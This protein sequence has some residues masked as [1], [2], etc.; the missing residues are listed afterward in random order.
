MKN[1]LFSIVI[2]IAVFII[3]AGFVQGQ[4]GKE[5]RSVSGFTGV[6]YGIPG[7]LYIKIGSPFSV[8]LEGDSR[9]LK[10][11]ETYIR[12][13]RLI[14][15]MESY[16]FFNDE[17]IDCYITMPSLK[18]LSVSGS[19]AARI[20]SPVNADALNLSVSG[21]GKIVAD[22]LTTDSFYSTISGSGDII[23]EGA[24][25][26]DRGNITISGSGSY[27]AG[28]FEIDKL[29]VNISGSGNC[30]CKPG[31]QLTAN[32]SGSGNVWYSG[33]PKLDVRASGSGHVRSK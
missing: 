12:D 20:E 24:G 29:T 19:G 8:V 26:A 23:I 2:I 10:D 4:P 31:D 9:Y 13:E 33:N 14:I 21:S 32:I 22:E 7:N 18:G 30:D 6:S 1:R 5:T 15:R 3:T 27:E 17:K 16:R 25:S 11:V 28:R